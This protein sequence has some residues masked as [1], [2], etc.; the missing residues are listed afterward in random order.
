MSRKK[1]ALPAP[2]QSVGKS[3]AITKFNELQT[4]FASH[5]SDNAREQG[6]Q[7]AFAQAF[8]FL[9]RDCYAGCVLFDAEEL[10]IVLNLLFRSARIQASWKDIGHLENNLDELMPEM[11]GLVVRLI[12]F[13]AIIRDQP[14]WQHF[15][16][17]LPDRFLFAVFTAFNGDRPIPPLFKSATSHK[18]RG[19][20]GWSPAP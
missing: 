16:E 4:E 20:H 7:G 15:E 13:K 11:R 6:K 17:L 5:L 14:A 3:K 8:L 10:G 18:W 1:S 19:R 12:A 9:L 2:R